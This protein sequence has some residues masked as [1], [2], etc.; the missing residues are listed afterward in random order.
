M[1]KKDFFKH[2]YWPPK[3]TAVTFHVELG[4]SL[5]TTPVLLSN[6]AYSTVS[7]DGNDFWG[8]TSHES[9]FTSDRYSSAND[10]VW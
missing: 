10:W 3:V 1:V 9:Q 2:P 7:N 4:L 5:S 8:N 6:D